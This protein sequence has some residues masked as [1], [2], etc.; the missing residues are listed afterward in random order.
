M[1]E[2]IKTSVYLEA[3]SI[4]SFITGAIQKPVDKTLLL[5]PLVFLP[6]VI[7]SWSYVPSIDEVQ[8]QSAQKKYFLLLALKCSYIVVVGVSILFVP[9][10]VG[11]AALICLAIG[12]YWTNKR[13][14]STNYEEAIKLLKQNKLPSSFSQWYLANKD[15]RTVAHEAAR[16]G[17]L[18]DNFGYWT[19]HDKNG[20]SV[21]H[22]AAKYGHLPY[23]F[24]LWELTDK[25]WVSVSHIAAQYGHL[26]LDFDLENVPTEIEKRYH[27][28]MMRK[29]ASKKQKKITEY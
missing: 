28:K 9:C 27:I 24:D 23:N 18:P 10:G 26:P 17:R 15:G 12:Y 21:A 11:L 29:M 7:W 3:L 4:A 25:N 8:N 22:E 20:W 16:Y 19:M 13:I 2:E 1:S 14:E 5:V 6:I